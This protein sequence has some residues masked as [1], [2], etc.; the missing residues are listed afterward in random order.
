VTEAVL[1]TLVASF[2]DGP[3]KVPNQALLVTAYRPSA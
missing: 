1:N 3:M 2:G